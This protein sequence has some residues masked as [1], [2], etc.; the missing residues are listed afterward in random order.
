MSYYLRN[1]SSS[2]DDSWF[3]I[4]LPIIFCIILI[5]LLIVGTNSCS[6]TTWN[7]GIC[8]NCEVRYELR[9]VSSGLKYYSCPE[10]GQ[11]VERY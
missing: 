5:I 3:S 7:N 9:G 10:C 4:I 11:E 1:H 6:A 2:S 8:S